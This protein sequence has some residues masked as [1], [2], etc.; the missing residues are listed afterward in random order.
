VSPAQCILSILKR[1]SEAIAPFVNRHSSFP[2]VSY[3]R[4]R[5]PE[6][7]ASLIEKETFL[8]PL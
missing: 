6:K 2:E 5:W 1:L 8:D 4:R 7:T 3:E